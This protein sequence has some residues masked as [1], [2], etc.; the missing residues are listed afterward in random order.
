MVLSLTDCKLEIVRR[1][2]ASARFEVL[3]RRWVV[4]R[5]FA[6]LSRCRRL[7]KDYKA[8]CETTEAWINIVMSGIADMI[9]MPKLI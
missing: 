2:R 5:T 7:S 1:A 9:F 3:P 4:E 6:W 8:M